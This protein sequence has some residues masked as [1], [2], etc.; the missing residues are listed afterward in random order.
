MILLE[1]NP[2]LKEKNGPQR[3]WRIY[4]VNLGNDDIL[5]KTERGKSSTIKN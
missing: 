5:H 3:F 2:Y 4:K 1:I